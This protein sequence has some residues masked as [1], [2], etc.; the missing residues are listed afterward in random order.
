MEVVT[1]MGYLIK[2]TKYN[3]NKRPGKSGN[4]T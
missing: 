4:K 2:N 3:E 1:L